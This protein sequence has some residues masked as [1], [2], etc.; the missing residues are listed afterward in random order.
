MKQTIATDV[1]LMLS[2][3]AKRQ[4][5]LLVEAKCCRQGI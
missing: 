3:S 5:P 2:R 4:K 1:E